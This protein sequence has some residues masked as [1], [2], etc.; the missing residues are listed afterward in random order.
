[1]KDVQLASFELTVLSVSGLQHTALFLLELALA[2]AF[3][4]G[5]RGY[6]SC[7]GT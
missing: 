4:L 2:W 1:M 6:C 5:V 3:Y 7:T